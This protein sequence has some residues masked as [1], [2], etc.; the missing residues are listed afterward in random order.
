[1]K[2]LVVLPI[3]VTATASCTGQLPDSFRLQQQEQ[4]FSSQLEIN[5][6]IDLLWVVDNSASMDISQDKLRKGFAGFANKYMQP[7]WDIRIAVIT[8]DTYLADPAFSNYLNKTIPGTVGAS[9][10]YIN[11]HLASFTNPSWNSSLVNLSTGK[12]DN[13][14]K[15]GELVPAWGANYSKLL[16]GLHDGPIA[17]FCFELMRYFVLG[18]AN[19]PIRDLPGA[20]TGT[21][22]C[23]HPAAGESSVT[24]CVNTIENDT[25]HSGKA[26]IATMPPAGVAG[27]AAWTNQLINDFIVNVTTGSVGQGSERG[28]A[29]VLQT[30]QDNESTDTAFFRKNSLRGIIFVSDEDD[31][32]IQ[33][34]T[35]P[36]AD[37]TPFSFYKCDQASLLNLNSSS[38]SAINGAGGYCCSVPANNCTYGSE[39][40]SCPSKTIDGR[41]YTMSVCPREELLV[42]VA[43]IKTQLDQFFLSLDGSDATNPNYF[44]TSIVPLTADSIDAMQVLRNT[45]D[46]AASMVK[47]QAVDRGDRY[48]ELANL[49]GN[50]SMSLNIADDDYSPILDTIGRA[51]I[52]KKS[53]FTL[54][55]APTGSEDM[56]VKLIHA[57]GTE[58]VI[59]SEKFVINDK[60]LIITDQD[61]VLSFKATDQVLINYQPKTVY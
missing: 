17:G 26:I 42:P 50:D 25:V 12:F 20:N 39:G 15:Y 6:K 10:T 30:L 61:L 48:I 53:T 43:D 5:T 54:A 51:I 3:I 31:Q 38:Q 22:N 21:S 52:D 18:A 40:T 29:S 14:V 27:D 28:L 4:V 60:S 9:S 41:T 7:T 11:D 56:I 36:S 13:G 37:F 45:E 16:P 33:I 59:S 23:I 34:P 35:N 44:I 8:T 57:D 24:Q 58:T 2:T 32:T 1:M 47:T 49:V 19:C 46:T 55:R